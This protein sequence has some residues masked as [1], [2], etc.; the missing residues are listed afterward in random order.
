MTAL[1]RPSSNYKRQIRPSS[2]RMLHKDYDRKGS[3]EKIVG[4][5]SQEP[6]RQDELTGGK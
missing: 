1:A 6:R 3:V 2:D 5:E 4:R